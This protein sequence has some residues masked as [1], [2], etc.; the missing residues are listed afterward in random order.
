MVKCS[1]LFIFWP[2]INKIYKAGLRLVSS[3]TFSWAIICY[4]VSSLQAQTSMMPS[5][6]APLCFEITSQAPTPAQTASPSLFS[7]RTDDPRSGR[8]SPLRSWGTL[9]QPHRRS[10]ASSPL[11]LGTTWITGCWS[12][13]LWRTVGWWDASPRRPT[14]ALC[15]KG[16]SA[17]LIKTRQVKKASFYIWNDPGLRL[18]YGS[19]LRTF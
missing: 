13:W 6:P 19:G 15:S 5:R 16:K 2:P 3:L 8:S 4:D 7:W 18:W 11:G 1:E 17:L 12:V 10:S 14:P 9:A